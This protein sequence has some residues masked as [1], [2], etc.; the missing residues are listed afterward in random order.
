MPELVDGGLETTADV[1]AHTNV[2][3]T[4]VLELHDAETQDTI[5]TLGLVCK[6]PDACSPTDGSPSVGRITD[7]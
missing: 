2:D 7:A 4:G 1:S 6:L 5:V 3:T